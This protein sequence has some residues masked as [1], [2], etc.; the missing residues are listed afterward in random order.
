M[1]HLPKRTKSVRCST[2]DKSTAA[3][4]SM[5]P[6]AFSIGVKTFSLR[7]TTLLRNARSGNGFSVFSITWRL[8]LRPLV[9]PSQYE[10]IQVAD[11]LVS[12]VGGIGLAIHGE[13]GV[14]HESICV[15]RQRL[16]CLKHWLH[17]PVRVRHVCHGEKD[18]T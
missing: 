9:S 10:E 5:M 7:L 2:S 12:N 17:R 3:F 8:Y 4:S 16:A 6:I 11:A 14:K 18:S 13:G 15:T 1:Q